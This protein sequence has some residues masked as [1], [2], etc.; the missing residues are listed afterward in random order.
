MGNEADRLLGILS[1][2]AESLSSTA[3]LGLQV[4]ESD[5]KSLEYVRTMLAAVKSMWTVS[6]SLSS[7][8]QRLSVGQELGLAGQLLYKPFCATLV[9]LLCAHPILVDNS[10]LKE[11]IA[12]L[13]FL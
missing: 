13:K 6:E 11:Y 9:Q 10:A 5:S 3:E 4:S 12:W 8:G 2:L 1:N 7:D